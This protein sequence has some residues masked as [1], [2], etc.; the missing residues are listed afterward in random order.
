MTPNDVIRL[1][2]DPIGGIDCMSEEFDDGDVVS[3]DDFYE[4]D[5]IYTEDLDEDP[6]DNE[7]DT[8]EEF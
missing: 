8:A 4:D 2:C 6:E 3:N 1:L 7:G 5:E